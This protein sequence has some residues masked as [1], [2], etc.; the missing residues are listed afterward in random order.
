MTTTKHVFVMLHW[1]C[2]SFAQ[3]LKTLQGLTLYAYIIKH[4]QNEPERF[5][6]NHPITKWH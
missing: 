1:S 4:W 6:I 3:R 5:I 2:L